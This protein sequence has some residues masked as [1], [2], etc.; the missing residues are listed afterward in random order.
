[1]PFG[2][3]AKRPPRFGDTTGLYV[4]I[5]FCEMICTFCRYT[6]DLSLGD[7]DP[8]ETRRNRVVRYLDALHREIAARGA[9]LRTFGTRVD[10]VFI[11]GG[12]P[13]VLS[14]SQLRWLFGVIRSEFD[15]IPGSPWCVEASPRTIVAE[16]GEEKLCFLR[17]EGVGRLSFGIQSFDDEV[18]R[19]AGRGRSR[20]EAT[21]A[22]VIASSLF[23]NYNF[24]L[25]QGLYKGNVDEVWGNLLEVERL[26]PP[27]LT[28]Y[29]GRFGD[30]KQQ[31][32]WLK[33]HPELF[34]GE[35]DTLLGRMLIW[36]R[37]R[38]LGYSQND[39]NRFAL[40]TAGDTFK[41]V[42]TSVRSD[43]LGVGASA[44]SHV[45]GLDGE[46]GLFFR[47]DTSL[48]GYLTR[49][50]NDL[51]PA[52]T[53]RVIDDEERLAASY[54]VGLRSVRRECEETV[55]LRTALPR[56]SEEYAARIERLAALGLVEQSNG[57]ERLTDLGCLFEDEILSL[58]YSPAAKRVIASRR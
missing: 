54:V 57:T 19:R 26:R 25:I 16:D 6:V 12:T 51:D 37:M 49:V 9:L 18:L 21:R 34:E 28:Y 22:C 48:D 56:L 17:D 53:A 10:S 55:R 23:P 39:G 47:N 24:D 33:A 35:E 50:E 42:R 1:M 32:A 4:H 58:F 11:G 20:E 7:T 31:W 43:L 40:G 13:T 29:H 52:S 41:K 30:D 44:Y 3:V 14:L 2:M 5:A 38:D 27:H 46:D 45:D 15:I 8:S 36:Q